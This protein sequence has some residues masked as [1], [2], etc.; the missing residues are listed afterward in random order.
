MRLNSCFLKSGRALQCWRFVLLSFAV[1]ALGETQAVVYRPGLLQA[2][3]TEKSIFSN[4]AR[5]PLYSNLTARV[6]SNGL[7][8]TYGTFMANRDAGDANAKRTAASNPWS[9]T[10]WAWDGSYSAFAYEGEMYLS[11]GQTLAMTGCFDDG[12]AA[13]ID[14]VTL[15]DQGDTSGWNAFVGCAATFTAPADGWYPFNAWVWDW[16]GGANIGGSSTKYVSGVQYAVNATIGEDTSYTDT[17]VW[18]KLTDDGKMSLLRVATEEPDFIRLHSVG[19]NGSDLKAVISV[20]E[21]PASCPSAQLVAYWGSSDGGPYPERW[22]HVAAV[23]TVDASDPGT[24]GDEMEFTVTGAAGASAVRFCLSYTDPDASI[25]S[26]V[27]SFAC[28]TEAL[29]IPASYDRTM[30]YG[31]VGTNSLGHQDAWPECF[32]RYYG[33][34]ASSATVSVQYAP[35]DAFAVADVVESESVAVSGDAGLGAP[36]YFPMPSITGKPAGFIRLKMANGN[37]VVSYSAPIAYTPPPAVTSSDYAMKVDFTVAGEYGNVGAMP[38]PVRLSEGFPYGFSYADFKSSG[39]DLAFTDDTGAIRYAYEVEKWADGG[40][41]LVWVWLPD[42]SQGAK[43]TMWYGRENQVSASNGAKV[44]FGYT[45]VWH[46]GE[47]S[48]T[49]VDATGHGLDG[50]PTKGA[51]ETSSAETVMVGT[52]GIV[53]TARVNAASSGSG[54]TYMSV[55]N[56]DSFGL[57]DTF[58][59]SGWFKANEVASYPRLFSRKI[60]YGAAEGFEIEME[61]SATV[62]SIRGGGGTQVKPNIND[63][64]ADWLHLSIAFSGATATLYQNGARVGSYEINPAT[65]NGRPLSFGNN[66]N[67]TEGSFNGQYD[68][69]RLSKGTNSAVRAAAEYASMLPSAGFLSPASAIS[70]DADMPIVESAFVAWGAESTEA[71]FTLA[72]GIGD[73]YIVFTDADSGAVVTN[74]LASAVDAR[75]VAQTR[76]VAVPASALPVRRTYNWAVY[77]TNATLGRTM[78]LYGAQ[79][80]HADTDMLAVGTSAVRYQ[81]AWPTAVVNGYGEGYASCSVSVQLADTPD[82]TVVT[83]ESSAVPLDGP[84]DLGKLKVF[85]DATLCS[86]SAGFIRAKMTRG[87]ATL[88]SSPIAYTPPAAFAASD[89]VM[90]INFT[91]AGEYENVGA[92]PVLVRLTEGFT[93]GFSY[94]DFLSSGA[95]L[96]F[97]DDT[98]AIR[99]AYEVAKW[100]DGGESLVWVWLPD[101]SQGAKFTMWYGRE[102]QTSSSDGAKVWGDYAGVW[103]MDEAIDS[104]TAATAV[105]ADSAHGND[106]V[107]TAGSAGDLSQMI[108]RAAVVGNGRVNSST[109]CVQQ[110]NRLQTTAAQKLG[111]VFTLSGWFT[112]N[113]KGQYPRMAGN[114]A[115]GNGANGWSVEAAQDSSTQFS[116]RANNTRYVVDNVDDL[117]EGWV[118][119][120][121]VFSNSTGRAYSNGALKGSSSDLTPVADVT[122]PFSFGAHGT[123]DEWSLNGAYDEIRL[124]YEALG[125]SRI[126]AEWATAKADA[127]FLSAGE[128]LSTSDAMPVLDDA[129]VSWGANGTE[130]TFTLASG[131]GDVYIVFTD[132]DSGAVITNVLATSLDAGSAA[133]T[134][135]VLIPPSAL[136]VRRTYNWAAFAANATLGRSTTVVGTDPFLS[137]STALVAEVSS[138][139]YQEPWPAGVLK[140]YPGSSASGSIS[141]EFAL[142]ADFDGTVV[143]TAAK[144]VSGEGALETQYI[145][146]DTEL[147]GRAA[148]FIRFKFVDGNDIVSRSSPIAY[149][150][151]A[152]VAVSDYA[153][154]VEYTVAGDFQN[155]GPMPVLVRLSEDFTH[156][157]TYA[158]FKSSGAD[159][160]FFNEAGDVRY[161]YEA[162]K[163]SADGESL[164]WV[165]LPDASQGAK[166]TMCYGRENQ[167]AASAGAKVWDGYVGVWHMGEASGTAVDAT[168]HGLNGTPSAGESATTSAEEVMVAADGVVGSARVNCTSNGSKL[169]YMSVPNYDSFGLGGK[170][171]I[172]GWFRANAIS[173]YP[174]IFSRKNVHDADEGFEIES[175]KDTTTSGTARGRKNDKKLEITW[176]DITK[177]WL[178]LTFVYD[179]GTLTA[180]TNGV[181]SA[182]G[183][184]N[185]ATDNERPLSFGNNSNGTEASFNGKYDEIRLY[186]GAMSAARVGAEHA[187]MKADSGFLSFGQAV[188]TSADMPMLGAA[189]V[190]CSWSN[191]CVEASITLAAG[192][193]DVYVVFTDVASG[194]VFTNAVAT[195]LDARESA[196]SVDVSFWPANLP[197]GRTYTWAAYARNETLA[198]ETAVFGEGELVTEPPLLALDFSSPGYFDDWPTVVVKQ[199]AP[200][201]TSGD[202]SVQY[203]TTE[204]FATIGCESASVAFSGADALHAP[205]VFQ[206]AALYGRAAGFV[207]VKITSGG[208]TGYSAPVAYTPPAPVAKTNYAMKVNFTIAGEFQNVGAMPVLVRLTNG[209]TQGFTYADFKSSG[210]DL[211]FFDE[212][213]KF[214]YAYDVEKWDPAG[215]SLVW[216][217]L[218]D[219]SQGAKFTMCYGRENQTAAFAGAKVWDGYVGVWH[220]REAS[221]PAVDATGH[222]LDGTPST[223]NSSYNPATIMV[224]TDGVVGNARVNCNANGS[225]LTYMSVP[226]YDSFGLGG[227]FTISGWFKANAVS[228]YPRIFSRKENFDAD[229]GFEIESAKDTTTS[230]T[231]R[232]RKNDKKITVGWPDLTADWCY[233]TFVYDGSTLTA[234]T[235]G[236][237]SAAGAIDAAT[238]NDK[239]LSFGNNSNGSE[240]SFN[241]KYDEIR[242]SKGAMSAARVGAEHAS[243]K[244]DAGFLSAGTAGPTDGSRPSGLTVLIW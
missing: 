201:A 99:Y 56:Y 158:D 75:T 154:K 72:S 78:V 35:T 6:S 77:A 206:L 170:F 43:F 180:F 84:G 184:I 136:P 161:A 217:W 19:K 181:Q 116:V 15:F 145:F 239:P 151:P 74:A 176:P 178:Y 64:S 4:K 214:R 95:D 132:V 101:A 210:A 164:I 66:S 205:Y 87:G 131:I 118:H 243:M 208:E 209:F 177:G 9:G 63:I 191:E 100:A 168:G 41:S 103:H 153:K 85:A 129:S 104:E 82:F 106:A 25:E 23:A 24:Y 119:L 109:E 219:A 65:D 182:A 2:K 218:P 194:A 187:S 88:Y 48:G 167:S 163:W 89:Y 14:G 86:R 40:E 96:A 122:Q 195:A 230:G 70:L 238:D 213:G 97:T 80:Y 117:A 199:Y 29:P 123:G 185:A 47:A 125:E 124:S 130:A 144:S 237:Q 17:T 39:A 92:M 107:P 223:Q 102:N 3:F 221:G 148:G 226:S 7:D 171:T 98:G 203:S 200:G 22:E 83:Y 11:A 52:A 160:A 229:E 126:A 150:P 133:Q 60:A 8:Y 112:M 57:G 142:T 50:T 46:M 174:R 53:G 222:G 196:Q 81:D 30:A 55:P 79:T 146:V 76:T 211:A 220:M 73:V 173:G 115:G 12:S 108:S 165:W 62:F 244:A 42:A 152:A 93:Y 202:V 120:A 69:I 5:P 51:N 105:S 190:A 207:R 34:N 32:V 235:N 225:K 127:G 189:S 44:W 111:G 138:T 198:C 224:A 172:S 233:L 236:V 36:Q 188:S 186:K 134:R 114:K 90:K 141:A 231:A 139:C 54:L 58:T 227:T 1:L 68:E 33:Q 59:I 135:T 193:G 71:T 175:A 13:V 147:Y 67:G 204:D 28:W 169:T 137:D 91:V 157:F 113:E 241:G 140:A 232:G 37:S 192:I 94:A 143:E 16:E 216:V 38:V 166:F 156:G 110:G 228:G 10:G 26:A 121:F 179:G 215:E 20:S 212:T 128:A 197:A 240:A 149:T 61:G 234:F 27:S 162:E 49:A 183:E 18:K 21:L 155:V 31:I 242:L 159:L 45:G